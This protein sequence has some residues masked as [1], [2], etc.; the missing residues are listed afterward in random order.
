MILHNRR[1][2]IRE[3]ADDFGISFSLCQ[4]IFMD[5][6]GMECAAAKIVT[7]LLNFEQNQRRMN[8]AQQMLTTF[9][10]D[11]DLV[12]KIITDVES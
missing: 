7:K 3:V 10:D 4:T 2:T 11:L 5:V 9:N 6:L 12:K 8:I 1:T